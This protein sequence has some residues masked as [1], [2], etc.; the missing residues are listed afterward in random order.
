MKVDA[1]AG[2]SSNNKGHRLTTVFLYQHSHVSSCRHAL[3]SELYLLDDNT[4]SACPTAE[5]NVCL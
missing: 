2:C 5:D 4:K 3:L 1:V